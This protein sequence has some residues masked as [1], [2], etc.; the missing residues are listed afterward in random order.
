MT[1]SETTKA[2]V[3]GDPDAQAENERPDRTGS[4]PDPQ[5][6]QAPLGDV[7]ERSVGD[8]GYGEGGYGESGSR[9]EWRARDE[10]TVGG[11]R[12]AGQ[13][14]GAVEQGDGF[15][16]KSGAAQTNDERGTEHLGGGR[17]RGA[18]YS[19]GGP[20]S[21]Q[22]GQQPGR[23]AGKGPKGYR[24]SDERIRDDVSE[25][26]THHGGIDASEIEVAVK[27]GE[28]TLTGTVDTQAEQRDAE[29]VAAQCSWVTGVHNGLRVSPGGS[30]GGESR[31]A[32]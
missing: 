11:L 2:A 30:H 16:G 23:F 15:S 3:P 9:R 10:P 7:G 24:R 25:H 13:A 21:N 4:E 1:T 29:A 12:D 5:N 27:D 18:D 31:P 32:A 19:Y 6:T 28:V 22:D 20:G 14:R 17:S 8:P 26:L